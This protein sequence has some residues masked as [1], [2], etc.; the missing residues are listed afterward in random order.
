MQLEKYHLKQKIKSNLILG[1]HTDEEIQMCKLLRSISTN[2]LRGTEAC[3]LI[4]PNFSRTVTCDPEI[5]LESGVV[6]LPN[7]WPKING[8]VFF[9]HP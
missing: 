7:K 1:M 9:V 3:M 8:C 2:G 5:H 6:G 4:R